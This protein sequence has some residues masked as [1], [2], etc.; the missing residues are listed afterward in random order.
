[1][2]KFTRYIGAQ[3]GNPHGFIG[4]ACCIIMNI[5]NK[6]MYKKTIDMLNLAASDKM[7]D[8][9]FGNGYLLKRADKKF[10]ADMYGIDISP[11]MCVNA[12]KRNRRAAKQN[13]L[14]LSVGDCC[15][16]E[17][18]ENTFDA[19]TSVN[20]VYFWEDTEKALREIKR[21][22]KPGK[23][24]YNAVY[25]KSFLDSLSYTKTGFKKFEEAELAALGEKVGFGNVSVCKIKNGKSFAV[26]YTK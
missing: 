7:L 1:M 25:T 15:A 26:I 6:P 11:D 14:H 16:L 5:I 9:G 13:R 17:Y 18:A 24:F 19:V 21:V 2:S 8:I 20:T 3:F 10:G 4:K 23:S 12:Q 22:L